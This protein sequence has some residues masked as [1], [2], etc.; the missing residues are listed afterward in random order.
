V[1]G[2]AD[3][4]NQV[5]AELVTIGDVVEQQL[6]IILRLNN[7]NRPERHSVCRCLATASRGRTR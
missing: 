7:H 1:S 4:R 5:T 6:G 3:L 2:F